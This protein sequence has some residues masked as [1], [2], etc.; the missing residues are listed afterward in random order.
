MDLTNT[1]ASELLRARRVLRGTLTEN[2]SRM[3]IISLFTS[4]RAALHPLIDPRI[5]LKN[6]TFFTIQYSTL[7]RTQ[8]R[9]CIN[10]NTVLDAIQIFR[11]F[12]V[13][14]S[15]GKNGSQNLQMMSVGSRA[16]LIPKGSF[17]AAT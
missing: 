6:A 10:A 13:I 5:L 7:V 15:P 8:R 9:S 16:L 14:G 1:A 3:R 2:F 17:V 12:Q 11:K 4:L